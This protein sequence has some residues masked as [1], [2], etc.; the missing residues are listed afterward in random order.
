MIRL[1]F[2]LGQIH[3]I[4]KLA[5]ELGLTVYTA[6]RDPGRAHLHATWRPTAVRGALECIRQEG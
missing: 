3:R 6:K 5:V 4:A 2:K 1:L